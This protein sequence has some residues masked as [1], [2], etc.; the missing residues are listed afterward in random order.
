MEMI[1]GPLVHLCVT[2]FFVGLV[3]SGILSMLQ[4]PQTSYP[5]Y[6]C[7]HSA[8]PT[9]ELKSGHTY[10]DLKIIGPKQTCMSVILCLKYNTGSTY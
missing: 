9:T 3:I 8:P 1:A 10:F 6:L 4:D 5:C 7:E 2:T